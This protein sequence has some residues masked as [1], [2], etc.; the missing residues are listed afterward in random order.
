M[1]RQLCCEPDH[2]IA[3]A[4]FA[5]ERQNLPLWSLPSLLSLLDN[6]PCR[7]PFGNGCSARVDESSPPTSE[8]VDRS[9]RIGGEPNAETRQKNW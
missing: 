2:V 8:T 7:F 1:D 9:E 4:L 5:A 3:S 6:S